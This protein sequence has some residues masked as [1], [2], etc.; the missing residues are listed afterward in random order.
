MTAQSIRQYCDDNL[1]EKYQSIFFHLSKCVC[2]CVFVHASVH[3]CMCTDFVH[4]ALSDFQLLAEFSCAHRLSDI[5][6]PVQEGKPS[7]SLPQ[8]QEAV[9]FL[10]RFDTSKVHIV[11]P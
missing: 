7:D 4:S 6:S 9:V 2:V 5:I 3:A 10:F 1:E 8:D 11:H